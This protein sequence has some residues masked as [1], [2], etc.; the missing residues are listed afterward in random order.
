MICFDAN[1]LIE[2]ILDRGRADLCRARIEKARTAKED[3]SITILTFSHVMYY[4]EANKLNLKNVELLLR[5]FNLLPLIEV[6]VAWAGA[7]Y[8][9]KDFEDG[10]QVACALRE[11]CSRFV[12]IDRSLAEKYSGQLQIELIR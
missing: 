5:T 2:I 9:G 1:V 11:N 3:G 12:T 4:A 7:H 8:Q 6:D 10:L